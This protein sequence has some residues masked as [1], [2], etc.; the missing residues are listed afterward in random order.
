MK[1]N[2]VA[3]SERWFPVGGSGGTN[4]LPVTVVLVRGSIGDYA[5]YIGI[6][7]KGTAQDIASFG[8]KISFAEALIHFPVGLEEANYRQ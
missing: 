7:G 1:H 4:R 8:D 2:I 6:G 3:V 5:A